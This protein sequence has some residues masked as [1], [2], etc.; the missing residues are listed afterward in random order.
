VCLPSQCAALPRIGHRSQLTDATTLR[1]TGELTPR[2][3]N[4]A[5]R[6]SS[7][8]KG[9][10]SQRRTL[11]MARARRA[12]GETG[13]ATDGAI[14]RRQAIT[15]TPARRL[16][17]KV[18]G[19]D[20]LR[21]RSGAR[22]ALS[23]QAKLPGAAV[24]VGATGCSADAYATLA[25]AAIIALP[26]RTAAAIGTATLAGAMRG[27]PAPLLL[28]SLLGLGIFATEHKREGHEQPAD[29]A[30]EHAAAGG[31]R[32]EGANQRFEAVFIHKICSSSWR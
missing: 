21:A 20:T 19:V 14:D 15:G 27:A 23:L 16:S 11:R 24:D 26:A 10:G 3:S 8:A 29:Q 25:G 2:A 22:H 1:W 6:S 17:G 30:G 4:A 13:S 32:R 5:E 28:A 12:A 31:P 9:T 18:A 7:T